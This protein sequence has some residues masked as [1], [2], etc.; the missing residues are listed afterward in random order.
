M[1]YKKEVRGRTSVHQNEMMQNEQ[2]I[3]LMTSSKIGFRVCFLTRVFLLP[4]FV[5]SG[6]R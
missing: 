2:V 4:F 3:T 1:T 6:R 5:R